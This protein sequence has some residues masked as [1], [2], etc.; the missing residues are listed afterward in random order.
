[1]TKKLHIA[2]IGYGKMGQEIEKLAICS[3]HSIDV[4]IDNDNHWNEHGNQLSSLDVA[5]EF[6][7][8]ETAPDNIRKCFHYG[9]PVVSGSTGWYKHLPAISAECIQ[10]DQALFYAPN[11]SLGVN[12][13][14][15]LNAQLARL[16]ADY[17]HY[18]PKITEI[19]HT[20]KL[21]APSGTALVLAEHVLS[22]R[23]DLTGWAL[24]DDTPQSTDIPIDALRLGQT[25]GTHI[26]SYTSA[27]DTIE[28][29]HTANNRK[30]FTEG[31]LMAAEWLCGKK[32]VFTMKHLM[33]L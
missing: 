12:I 9:I 31:A 16:M 20:Q 19:H 26:V 18:A 17:P 4:I 5:I 33:N 2:L 27:I 30:G 13:L 32:G 7:T 24:T 29:K 8:P 23:N 14:F 21:D 3:G 10:A 15:E 1:M 11:F 6:T 25:P 22:T 28:I